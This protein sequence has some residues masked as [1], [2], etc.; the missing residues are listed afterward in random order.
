MKSNA[1]CA[2]TYRAV[3]VRLSEGQLCAGGDRGKDS[4]RGDSGG[5]LMSLKTNNWYAAGIVSFGPT[6]CGYENWP[7]IYTRVS[8]Y[9]D[10]IVGK[11]K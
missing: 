9:M 7:G 10:W 1:E 8:Q 3:R 6:P 4:C 5:P 2:G 11:L